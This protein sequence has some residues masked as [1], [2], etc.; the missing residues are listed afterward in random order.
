MILLKTK[1]DNQHGGTSRRY[2]IGKPGDEI[3]G[4]IYVRADVEVPDAAVIGF[5]KQVLVSTE[6]EVPDAESSEV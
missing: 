5:P 4:A 3:S 6:K 2:M 1:E